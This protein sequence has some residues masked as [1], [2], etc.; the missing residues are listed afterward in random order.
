MTAAKLNR[1][2]EIALETDAEYY[3]DLWV[4]SFETCPGWAPPPDVAAADSYLGNGYFPTWCA[5]VVR[6]Q[7]A[8]AAS[9]ARYAFG[10]T[11]LTFWPWPNQN[12]GGQNAVTRVIAVDE[13]GDG[14]KDREETAAMPILNFLELLTRMG[15][16]FCVL[17]E[18]TA[19]AHVV[20]GFTSKQDDVV[21]VLLYAH[22]SRDIQSRSQATFDVTL[23]LEDVP[24]SDVRVQEYRFDKE[25]NSYYRLGRQLRDRLPGGPNAR[26]LAVAEVDRLT[27]DLTGDD[28]S[29]QI[30]ALKRVA[31]VG[32][33]HDGIIAAAF[34]LYERTEHQDVRAAIEEAGRQIVIR[35]VCYTVDEVARVQEL[36][37]LR[38]TR[39]SHHAVGT[40]RALQLALTVA[41]NGVNFL[42]IEPVGKP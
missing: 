41:A 10:E 22:D 13:D 32:A 20:S 6:R 42:V 14:S 9:D 34:Q 17:P 5:D 24:W 30:A 12:F 2:K 15:D 28:R 3:A 40:D 18:Q 21:C 27:A 11:I 38:V 37:T 19:A 26:R 7:L 36:S 25:H 23:D 1:A 35:K 29:A 33:L 16:R 39:N 8:Q 4:N 31:S